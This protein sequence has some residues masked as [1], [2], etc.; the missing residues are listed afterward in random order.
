MQGR[1]DLG[2]RGGGLADILPEA[3]VLIVFAA[4]F[5]GTGVMRFRYE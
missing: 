3:G 2:S 1:L 5:F 4:F